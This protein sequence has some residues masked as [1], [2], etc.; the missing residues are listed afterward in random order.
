[1]DI[2]LKFSSTSNFGYFDMSKDTFII[3]HGFFS[4]R[5]ESWVS[6]MSQTILSK[7]DANVILVDWSDGANYLEYYELAAVNTEVVGVILT[8]LI[9]KLE[10]YHRAKMSYIHIIGHSLGAHV[11]GFAGKAHK[12]IRYDRIT[13]LDPAGEFFENAGAPARLDKTDAKFVDVIHTS[14]GSLIA[15]FLKALILPESKLHEL[16]FGIHRPIGH[17]DF[18]PNGGEIQPGCSDFV[19]GHSRAYLLFTESI[20][21][22]QKFCATQCL[23]VEK[24]TKGEIITP[25]QTEQLE[26]RTQC[27]VSN[28]MGFYA[29]FLDEPSP[30]GHKKES[31]MY[32]LTTNNASPF[33]TRSTCNPCP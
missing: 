7:M 3:V 6:Q 27:M 33:G 31:I 25:I 1:M 23:D 32:Y 15:S 30:S 14:G 16:R 2:E 11:A 5:K 21:S 8:L 18:Y 9:R 22:D 20:D 29:T 4:S 13:G 12:D 24:C 28:K 19:C 10:H 26:K 17:L